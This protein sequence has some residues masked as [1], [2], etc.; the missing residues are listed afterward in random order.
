MLRLRTE[1]Q[2]PWGVEEA[3][4]YNGVPV[5]LLGAGCDWKR[6]QA[7]G[8][9]EQLLHPILL[10]AFFALLLVHRTQPS[11]LTISEL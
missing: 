8:T 11:S 4:K 10:P 2:S 7:L 5:A 9:E 3:C 1:S 6:A